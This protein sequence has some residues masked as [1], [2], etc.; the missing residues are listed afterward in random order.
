MRGKEHLRGMI[1][2]VSNPAPAA[3]EEGAVWREEG[4]DLLVPGCFPTFAN[5]HS[6]ELLRLTG[7]SQTFHIG[8]LVCPASSPMRLQ[9]TSTSFAQ[10]PS[11]S[12][13][14]ACSFCASVDRI[15]R[16]SHA[17]QTGSDAAC[18]TI[19]EPFRHD[20]RFSAF[21]FASV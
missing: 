7:W 2:L 17:K 1:T 4:A 14:A 20:S 18:R 9:Q 10:F 8:C 19:A 5:F 15:F 13:T 21:S 16:S 3:H 11:C 12:L 6:L